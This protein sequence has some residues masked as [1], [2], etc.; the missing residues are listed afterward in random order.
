MP[1]QARVQLPRV[2]LLWWS[3]WLLG[4][5]MREFLWNWPA[6]PTVENYQ[7]AVRNLLITV[8]LGLSI[9]WPVYRL[10]LRRPPRPALTVALDAAA[11][12]LTLQV[13]L[14]PI[15]LSTH[16]SLERVL[17]IDATLAVWAA[18]VGSFI[19]WGLSSGRPWSRAGWMLLA[20]ALV[21]AGPA[22]S[23][24]VDDPTRAAEWRLWSPMGALWDLS[25]PGGMFVGPAV[26]WRALIIAALAS[27]AWGLHALAFTE[28]APVE[29]S[30]PGP[31]SAARA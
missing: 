2:L 8:G 15:R 26:W 14:W 1:R 19:A 20:T 23:V 10:S 31:A 22:A 30:P 11:L 13:V 6:A 28:P 12:M 9:V 7:V 21:V 5:W 3:L 4:G 18:L 25:G 24:M 16:W 27:L 29:S 17:A